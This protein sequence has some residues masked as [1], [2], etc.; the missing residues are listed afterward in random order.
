MITEAWKKNG[1]PIPTL[2]GDEFGKFVGTEVA[3]WGKVVADAKV[4]LE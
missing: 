4:K 2:A 3:R 1:S